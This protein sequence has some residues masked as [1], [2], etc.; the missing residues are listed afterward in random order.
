MDNKTR[1]LESDILT[2]RALLAAMTDELLLSKQGLRIA[3]KLAR[4][5]AELK[6]LDM[7]S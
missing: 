5:L 4:K 2:N 1:K 7:L 3:S 6:K